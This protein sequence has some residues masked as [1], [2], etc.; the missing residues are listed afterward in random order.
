MIKKIL[1]KIFGGSWR[2]TLLGLACLLIGLRSAWVLWVPN[3]SIRFNVLYVLPG[4]LAMMIV[5]WALI[6]ARDHQ[7]R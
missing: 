4:S 3:Q 1:V 5:G 7:D 2:T 6:H